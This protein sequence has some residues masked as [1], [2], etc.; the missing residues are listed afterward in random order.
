ML[1]D[2]ASTFSKSRLG[3]FLLIT[4]HMLSLECSMLLPR[5][6]AIAAAAAPT[7]T[8]HQ[9]LCTATYNGLLLNVVAVLI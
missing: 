9:L 5:P 4:Q 2:V 6:C 3:I 1:Q 8:T 7:G